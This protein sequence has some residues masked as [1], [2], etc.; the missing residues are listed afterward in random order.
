MSTIASSFSQL[1]ILDAIDKKQDLITISFES[2]VETALKVLKDNNIT[3]APVVDSNDKIIRF[4]DIL[5]IVALLLKITET[6]TSKDMMS[7][8][9][10]EEKFATYPV[11]RI[12]PSSRNV[13]QPLQV[14]APL[15]E[16]IHLFSKGIKRIPV[17][18][19][20]V[21]INVFTQSQF[22]KFLSNNLHL[23][24]QLRKKTCIE[25]DVGT[26]GKQ[27]LKTVSLNT[28]AID[29]FKIMHEN[30]LSAIA[31]NDE[32]GELNCQLSATDLKG[33]STDLVETSF[34]FATL[35]LPIDKFVK[36][37]SEGQPE[38]KT[39]YLVWSMPGSSFENIIFHL[40]KN[41]VHRIY[42]INNYVNLW[43]VVSITDICR[44]IA[45]NLLQ[46]QQ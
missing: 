28:K 2:N 5:D 45:N 33:I 15:F 19:N 21:L 27:D 30:G 17:I 43:G 24:E 10:K 23:V 35:D 31:V 8:F 7:L 1:R 41:N 20:G 36:I 38:R 26:H 16:A 46:Q 37:L 22:L 44:V 6:K 18:S 11:D 4:I 32:E 12:E 39:G 34:T 40:V 42:L 13:F 3:S 29:A 14:E 25:L 9:K